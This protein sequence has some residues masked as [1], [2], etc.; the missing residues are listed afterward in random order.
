MLPNR[1]CFRRTWIL[2]LILAILPTIS[3]G[4]Y[5]ARHELEL[6]SYYAQI[7]QRVDRRWI[8][9]DRFFENN[10][11]A[12]QNPEVREWCA[13]ALGRIASPRALP[14]LYR[15]AHAGDTS[16]RAAAAFSIGEII[17]RELPRDSLSPPD[18]E[19]LTT[20]RAL[21][22]DR[23][24]SVRMRAMEALGKIGAHPEAAAILQSL[25]RFPLVLNGS[26]AERACAEYAI[27]ALA[28]IKDQSAISI[29]EQLAGSTDAEIRRRANEARAR[30]EQKEELAIATPPASSDAQPTVSLAVLQ[31]MGL[32]SDASDPG[33][34]E[35]SITDTTSYAL[36]SSRKNST[37]AVVET[38]R[39]TLEIEL[40]RDDAPLTVANFILAAGHGRFNFSSQDNWQQKKS[41]FI[42]NQ[43][44]GGLQIGG[45]VMSDSNGF[46]WSMNGE[47]NMRPFERGSLG[48][49][50]DRAN[51]NNK[52][53]F[54]ALAP[55][56]YRDG[57]DTCFGRVISG[58]PVADKIVAGD[59]IL[60]I[61]IKDTISFLDHVRY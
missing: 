32:S 26:P 54:L 37:V 11:L 56:P 24:I 10:L 47:V 2:G 4:R 27:T 33:P 61:T 13:I 20:L 22:S 31:R 1:T 55:L 42:F 6:N 18:P 50:V 60:R 29:L 45:E 51:P 14:L 15:A 8:G 43:V 49:S 48:L 53:L 34:V 23:S 46:G 19:A 35:S 9:N 25:E 40:F 39:G 58:M 59:K 44:T 52:S 36:A 12:N 41:G 57:V 30:I 38:S 16:V 7:L 5:R 3:C 17:D 28:R 21:L